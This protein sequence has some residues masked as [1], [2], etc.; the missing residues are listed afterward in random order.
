MIE[1]AERIADGGIA[2]VTDHPDRE[3]EG[4]L[5]MAATAAT[6]EH[7]GFFLQRTSG[8]ICVGVEP[9]RADALDLPPMVSS[10]TELHGTAFTVSVD[11]R[12]GLT[13]RLSATE[14]A[15]TIAALDHVAVSTGSG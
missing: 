12:A 10:K 4:D 13:T 5:I 1:A 3:D 7:V 11:V 8:L 15:N 9:G 6:Q 14:R 2:V